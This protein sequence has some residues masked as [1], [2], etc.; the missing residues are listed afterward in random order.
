MHAA[1][2]DFS[3][4][5]ACKHLAPA[6]CASSL[7]FPALPPHSTLHT[8][9]IGCLHMCAQVSVCFEVGSESVAAILA[10]GAACVARSLLCSRTRG[11][12]TLGPN[13]CAR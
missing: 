11:R 7:A 2:G 3:R 1:E 4:L 6:V 10:L 5:Q 12:G 13:P 9:G 8:A